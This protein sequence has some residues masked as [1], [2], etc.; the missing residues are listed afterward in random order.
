[1]KLCRCG[2]IVKEKCETCSPP[3]NHRGQT[4]KDRGYGSDHRKASERYRTEHPLCERCMNIVGTVEA[5]PSDDMH[6]LYPISSYP[7]R[8]MDS[9]YWLALCKECHELL[10]RDIREGLTIKQWSLSNY[11]NTINGV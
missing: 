7:E 3:M 4:T 2:K 6:H 11:E 1:M 8:R 5:K 10:E 9:R